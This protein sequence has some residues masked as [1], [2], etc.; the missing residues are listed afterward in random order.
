M[1][2]QLIEQ[3]GGVAFAVKVVPGSKQQRIV[4][5]YGDALKVA[6]TAPPEHGK[7][8]AA[9]CDLLAA[10]L[11]VDSRSVQITAGGQS[12]KKRVFVAGLTAATVRQRLA[13]D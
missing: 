2:L 12:P 6:V 13:V 8:N 3:A 7:A 9:V 11:G 4:G 1:P 5:N 10:S